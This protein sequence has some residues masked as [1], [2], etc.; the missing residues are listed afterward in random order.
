MA[1]SWNVEVLLKNGKQS[2]YVFEGKYEEA[3]QD[4]YLSFPPGAIQKVR[5]TDEED[6]RIA[7]QP[8]TNPQVI[9]RQGSFSLHAKS[10]VS[11]PCFTNGFYP[12]FTRALVEHLNPFINS[13]QTTY[14]YD[15]SIDAFRASC[16]AGEDELYHGFDIQV[17]HITIR[18]YPIGANHFIWQEAPKCRYYL[19]ID[20]SSDE[21]LW[22]YYHLPGVHVEDDALMEIYDDACLGT[23]H[24]QKQFL[25]EITA[26]EYDELQ[27]V[28]HAR[29]RKIYLL[30]AEEIRKHSLL[31]LNL[32]ANGFVPK[33][34]GFWGRPW[35]GFLIDTEASRMDRYIIRSSVLSREVF[36][37]CSNMEDLLHFYSRL[38]ERN[39]E[40]FAVL[41]KKFWR[42]KP[43]DNEM[44]QH[45]FR[46]LSLIGGE[47][48]AYLES[49]KETDLGNYLKQANDKIK[50][51]FYE[52]P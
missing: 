22:T 23:A 2:D 37:V 7:L 5:V 39:E 29:D 32:L 47:A 28:I 50:V 44:L 14:R 30:S 36:W 6:T 35:K 31:K 34:A 1:K 26:E 21:Y 15:E 52:I 10:D 3:R 17:N 42:E 48:R 43:T 4:A 25:L 24:Y 45:I 49:I 38:R 51:Y 13:Q 12:V 18:V 19:N 11:F 46:N 40:D 20:P 41:M 33:E 8:N 16:H 9:Y 27:T